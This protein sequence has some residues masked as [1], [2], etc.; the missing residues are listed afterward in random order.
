MVFAAV[1][2]VPVPAYAGVKVRFINPE[3]YNDAGSLSRACW[4]SFRFIMLLGLSA[5]PNI[6]T[7]RRPGNVQGVVVCAERRK[8]RGREIDWASGK[9]E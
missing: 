4:I 3:C 2:F 7:R 5:F 8:D 9:K 6:V 1:L